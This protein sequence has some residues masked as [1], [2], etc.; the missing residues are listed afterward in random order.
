MIW[1]EQQNLMEAIAKNRDE[2]KQ[3]TLE[4]VIEWVVKNRPSEIEL[5][6]IIAA[7]LDK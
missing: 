2:I 6:H 1:P 5:I 4:L 7:L 3:E